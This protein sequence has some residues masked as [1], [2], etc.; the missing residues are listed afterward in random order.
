MAYNVHFTLPERTLGKA[1]IVVDVKEGSN[2]LGKLKVSQGAI[3]WVGKGGG[4]K[5]TYKVNWKKFQDI[6]K[7][8]NHK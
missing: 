3:E 6:M 5:N 2:V 7:Q 1:D 4:K 8:K